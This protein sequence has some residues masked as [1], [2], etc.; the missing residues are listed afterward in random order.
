[1]YVTYPAR[2][3][4]GYKSNFLD[5]CLSGLRF[6]RELRICYQQAENGST[7]ALATVAIPR[8]NI[9]INNFLIIFLLSINIRT[10]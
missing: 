8:T 4:Q 3:M 5:S 2:E 10:N 6:E 7:Q 9:K 1:L